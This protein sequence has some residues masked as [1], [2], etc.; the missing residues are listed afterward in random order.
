MNRVNDIID[1]TKCVD[2]VQDTMASDN[3]EQ[4]AAHIHRYLSLDKDLL[5]GIGKLLSFVLI[6]ALLFSQLDFEKY[7]S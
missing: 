7:C 2:G 5:S 1:L 4:A 6:E 3:Y